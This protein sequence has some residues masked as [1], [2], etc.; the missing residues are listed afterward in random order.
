MAAMKK[1]TATIFAILLSIFS[2]AAHETY[3]VE[4]VASIKNLKG[5]VDIQRKDNVI[6]G[7]A[8]LILHD[9]DLVVTNDESK[10]TIIFRDGSV[11][12]L[13]QNTKF[14]IEKSDEA[15]NGSR[16][17]LNNF[18][19]KLGSFWGK[20]TKNRQETAIST[21]TAT[22]GIKGTIVALHERENLLDVSLSEGLVSIRNRHETIDLQAGK[23][24][25]NI[26]SSGT[27]TD[28]IRELPYQ[29]TIRPD[30]DK[31]TIPGAGETGEIYFTIQIVDIKTNQ[32]V[33]RGGE[34][35]ISLNHDKIEFEPGIRLNSR[36]YARVRATVL[37]FELNDYKDGLIE[38][39]ALMDG[40]QYL[41][42][43]AGM[44][45]LS[46][47][48]PDSR[49]KPRKIDASTGDIQ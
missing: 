49:Q 42:I 20:F 9:Q 5:S 2:F 19:L 38:I 26:T 13:F 36:G 45:V 39:I 1:T 33:P 8:G 12:R 47:D 48:L 21:P 35:Y 31:L 30:S 37:P 4:A 14:L 24:A 11:I 22:L 34:V 28:K 7:R 15:Q 41:D 16:R 46:Y 23:M 44:T 18:I 25:E 32:N 6:A 29:V 27:I 43:S 40:E 10:V 3:A 17:F